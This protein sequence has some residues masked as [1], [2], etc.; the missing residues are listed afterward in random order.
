MVVLIELLCHSVIDS[1][2]RESSWKSSN[3]DEWVKND[4]VVGTSNLT[5]DEARD[6]CQYF[7]IRYN[8]IQCRY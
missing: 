8:Q 1:F 5:S 2:T 7:F 3:G 6:L 4:L